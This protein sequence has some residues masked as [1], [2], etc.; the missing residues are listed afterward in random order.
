MNKHSQKV[1]LSHELPQIM[2]QQSQK[3]T[4]SHWVPQIMIKHS[5]KVSLSHGMA[6]FIFKCSV[7]IDLLPKSIIKHRKQAVYLTT[8]SVQRVLIFIKEVK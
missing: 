1:T 3:I 2:T 8:K 7:D 5:P 4:L 6:Y